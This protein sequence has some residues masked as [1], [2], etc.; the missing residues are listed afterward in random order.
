MVVLRV[1]LRCFSNA[2]LVCALEHSWSR[3]VDGRRGLKELLCGCA[4][5]SLS[6]YSHEEPEQAKRAQLRRQLGLGA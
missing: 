2:E 1:D 4:I 3:L 5:D 6:H